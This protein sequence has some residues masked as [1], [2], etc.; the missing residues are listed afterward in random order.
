CDG[1]HDVRVRATEPHGAS[2]L[3]RH[4]CGEFERLC[5]DRRPVPVPEGKSVRGQHEGRRHLESARIQLSERSRCHGKRL[6][7]AVLLIMRRFISPK[8]NYCITSLPLFCITTS[9]PH[10]YLLLTSHSLTPA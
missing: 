9:S 10:L 5:G 8:N 2:G 3:S 1:E 4:Q 6:P 7:E